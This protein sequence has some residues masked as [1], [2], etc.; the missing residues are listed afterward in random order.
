M[1]DAILTAIDNVRI[2]RVEMAV[3]SITESSG[4]G[5]SSMVQ[6]PDQRDF[7]GNAASTPPMSA[8]SFVDL[9]NDQDRN[10]QTRNVENLEDGNFPALML[11]YDQ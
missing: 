9:N 11:N 5:P 8:S 3:R 10:D 6:I 4:R 7:T 2:P 1:H